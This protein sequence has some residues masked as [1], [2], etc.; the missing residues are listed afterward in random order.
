MESGLV[1]G[2]LVIAAALD[3]EPVGF[4]HSCSVVKEAAAVVQMGF[5]E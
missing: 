4:L 2:G 3:G 1:L 5:V